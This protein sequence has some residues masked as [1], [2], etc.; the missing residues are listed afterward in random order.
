MAYGTVKADVLQSDTAGTPPQFN[1]GNGVQVGTLC[2]AWVSY[3][4]V[5]QAILSSF[6]VSSVTYGSV[7]TYTV[8]FTNAFAN[9]NYCIAMGSNTNNSGGF[10]VTYCTASSTTA[11]GLGTYS[12]VGGG[13]G[14]FRDTNGVYIAVFS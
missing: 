6:N 7:G 3:N 12:I 5:G 10:N 11:V 9:T 4:G 13:S 14:A 1:G 2:R 8:N